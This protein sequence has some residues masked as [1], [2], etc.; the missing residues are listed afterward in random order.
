M[1][2]KEFYLMWYKL[3]PQYKNRIQLSGTEALEVLGLTNTSQLKKR[4][5]EGSLR[6][7]DYGKGAK[8]RYMYFI[9]D[10]LKEWTR[11]QKQA[12]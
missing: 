6:V 9:S 12:V 11:K 2:D 8:P 3:N 7:Q 1:S 4:V 5:K 10:I